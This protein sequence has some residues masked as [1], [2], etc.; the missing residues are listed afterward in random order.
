MERALEHIYEIPYNEEDKGQ[1]MQEEFDEIQFEELVKMFK[2]PEDDIRS[3]NVA[4][5]R[6]PS[7]HS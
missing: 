1:K 7:Q 3:S 4:H 5:S 2:Y 6:A